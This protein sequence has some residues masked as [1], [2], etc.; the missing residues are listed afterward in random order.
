MAKNILNKR[1]FA[2]G[3]KKWK[4]LCWRVVNHVCKDWTTENKEEMYQ[5]MYNRYFLPNSPTLVNAG[6][7]KHAGLSACFVLPFEDTI[8]QIYNY[9][10]G[11]L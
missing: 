1:Y 2:T 5:M 3:E 10:V 6:K 9:N 7:N 4:D 11:F 8:E